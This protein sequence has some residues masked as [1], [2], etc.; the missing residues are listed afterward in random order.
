M[1]SLDILESFQKMISS[2]AENS[3]KE[4]YGFSSIDMNTRESI[5]NY[6]NELIVAKVLNVYDTYLFIRKGDLELLF[7]RSGSLT[8]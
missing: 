2:I 8:A 6:I 4:K 1:I 3:S 7:R 5:T